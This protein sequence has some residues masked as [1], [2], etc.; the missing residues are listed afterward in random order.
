M[1]LFPKVDIQQVDPN[2][3]AQNAILFSSLLPLARFVL[4]SKTDQALA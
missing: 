4:R 3:S 2:L 1:D